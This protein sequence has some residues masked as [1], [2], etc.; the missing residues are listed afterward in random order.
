MT[1]QDTAI[2]VR[3]LQCGYEGAIILKDLS[4]TVSRGEI[5]VVAG[6]SGCGKSTLLKSMIGLQDPFEGDVV[7]FGQSFWRATSEERR[8]LWSKMGILYQS[9]AL[10]SAMTV[11]ENVAL[12]LQEYTRLS[13]T[14]IAELV[15]LKLAFVG[16]DGFEE[17][18]PAELSGG[19]RKRAGLAR[20]MALDPKILFFDEP[21]AGLDPL[22][23][24]RLDQLILRIRHAF[25]TTV[26]VVSHELDSIFTIADRIIM[27]DGREKGAIAIGKPHELRD[28]GEP[29]VTEFLTRGGYL[30]AG[31]NA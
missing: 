18:F 16:L 24:A 2:D 12:P 8:K 4:F 19:M 3:N 27:L 10:W 1:D 20:A 29:R 25:D 28:G 31:G 23:S 14:R 6:P 21:S 15:R 22:T 13:K 26:V 9:S 17:K 30:A 5:F 7:Y 11:A